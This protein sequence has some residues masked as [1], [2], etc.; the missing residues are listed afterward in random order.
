MSSILIK[1][2]TIVN[3]GTDLNGLKKDIFILKGVI[4]EIGDNINLDADQV[5]SEESLHVSIGLFDLRTHIGDPGIETK[6]DIISGTNAAAKGGFTGIAVMPNTSPAID[7]RSTIEYII[8]KSK[9]LLID[10]YPMGSI[11][12]NLEGKE[13]AE[14]YDMKNAGAVA[15]F[16]DKQAIQNPSLLSKALLYTKGFNGLILSYANDTNINENGQI[17]EGI[18]STMLGLKSIPHLAEEIQVSRDIFLSEYNNTSLHFASISSA[19]SVQLIKSAQQNNK[20]TA[21]IAAH[22]LFFTDQSLKDFESNFKVLPPFRLQK[23]I[24]ALIEGLKDNTISIICSDH[25]PVEI[26][27]KNREFNLAKFG[28]IN[29][30]TAFPSLLTKLVP[31]TNL[32][33][34]ID[35]MAIQ[36]RK[37]LNL[38]IPKIEENEQANLTLFIPNKKWKFTK[39]MIVSKSKNSPFIDIEFTGKVI[40]VINNNQLK[41]NN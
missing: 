32:E 14:L 16:D 2:V 6:E 25:T 33:L 39:E 24:D 5:I 29:L 41:L 10:V 20:I 12:K 8:N 15:F 19:K 11:S 28:I 18:T 38:T 17:N 21:D 22:Q 34:V 26:E 40:G 27:D 31:L 35:K 36:P 23:D 9:D 3:P 13:L 1:N 37:L 4:K 7:N 30:Q